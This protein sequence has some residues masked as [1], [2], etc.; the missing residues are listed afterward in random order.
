VVQQ[1][2][3][4]IVSGALRPG[5]TLPV[6]PELA[7][8]FGV[9]RTV[10]REAVRVLVSK[11]LLAV[12]QG[13]GMRVQPPEEWDYLDPL[14][15][16]EQVRSGQAEDLLDELLEVRCILEVEVAALAAERRTPADL[17]ALHASL[18]DMAQSLSEPDRFTRLDIEF[19]GRILAAAR[20][21]LLR[22]ALRPVTETLEAG[23]FLTIRLQGGAERS[24]GGHEE[25][26]AA[27]EAGDAQAARE[28]MRGHVQQFERDIHASLNSPA[29]WDLGAQ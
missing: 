27:I 1:I 16:F 29:T 12:R 18:A 14:V 24:M 20:N 9:S 6:E 25:I 10:I 19:H 21:R 13:S 15:L 22:E 26:Y 11:G 8:Q 17:A 5:E 3:Q 4:R 23:R 2:A 7:Q 28:A